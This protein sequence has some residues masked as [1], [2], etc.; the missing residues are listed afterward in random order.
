[1]PVGFMDYQVTEKVMHT[2]ERTTVM[3][4]GQSR[5]A[6]GVCM[7]REQCKSSAQGSQLV[8]FDMPPLEE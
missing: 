2:T 3:E 8:S 4:R 6:Q 7:Q 5:D 1:M